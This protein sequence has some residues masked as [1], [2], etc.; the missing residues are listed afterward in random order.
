MDR[1]NHHTDN[2]GIFDK[3]FSIAMRQVR[4]LAPLRVNP[5]FLVRIHFI[6]GFRQQFRQ[7]AKLLFVFRALGH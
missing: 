2:P 6:N 4:R 1:S 5:N 3:G 7:F